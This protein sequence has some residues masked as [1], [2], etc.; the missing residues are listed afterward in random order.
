VS[1]NSSGERRNN[2]NDNSVRIKRSTFNKIALGAVA[3]LAVATF[4]GGYILGGMNAGL[5]GEGGGSTSIAGTAE[6]EGG[7]SDTVAPTQ[8]APSGGDAALTPAA[9]QPAAPPPA[10]VES[11]SLDGAITKGKQDAPVKMVEFS[12]FQ[13]PFCK[14]HFDETLEQ[15]EKEYVST[16]KVQY[17]YK[18]YPLDFHPNAKPAAVAAECANEQGKFWEYHDVLFEKQT[19][20]ETQDANASATTFKTFATGLKLDMNKFN[21]C[22]DSNKYV[23]KVDKELQEG[24]TYGVSG[25]P[26]FYIGNE[27]EGYTQIVGAQ[28]FTTI[29]QTID[30]LL[31]E[32]G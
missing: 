8:Q 3:A 28:P 14:R 6:E 22:L 23:E 15:I 31:P 29:R 9:P 4:F 20:W 1:E 16:G 24:S 26:T 17:V 10:R 32:G 7:G 5:V 19:Q 18:H 27:Q 21:S 2:G 30:Q 12:D 11:I 25:T 13:C